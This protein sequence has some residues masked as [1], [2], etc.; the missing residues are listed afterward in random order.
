MEN[1]DFQNHQADLKGFEQKNVL[2]FRLIQDQ[3]ENAL[4][5][6]RYLA[7]LFFSGCLVYSLI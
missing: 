5:I 2:G 7:V 1:D 3:R 6:L 4:L